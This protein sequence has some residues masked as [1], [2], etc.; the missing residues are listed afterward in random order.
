[1][2]IAEE[3]TIQ[4]KEAL[5]SA[6]ENEIRANDA[7]KIAEEQA[8]RTKEALRSAEINEAAARKERED[9]D[10]S[11]SGKHYSFELG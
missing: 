7:L 5:R 2:K 10:D 6:E 11:Q 3:Q 9:D 8:I 4:T 1:M